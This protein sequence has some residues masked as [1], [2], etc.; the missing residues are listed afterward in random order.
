MKLD[1]LTLY[2]V[3]L[4]NSM[5]VAI[6]WAAIAYRY[7]TFTTARIWLLGCVLTTIG[8]GVVPPL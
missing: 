1:F 2:I 7:R 4:L 3:I 8:G 5:T 6:I